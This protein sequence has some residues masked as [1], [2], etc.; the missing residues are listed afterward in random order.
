[1][2]SCRVFERMSRGINFIAN[3]IFHLKVSDAVLKR[4]NSQEPI[5][6]VGIMC[7]SCASFDVNSLCETSQG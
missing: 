7:K 1:M 6:P 3:I 4:E 2:V 5:L